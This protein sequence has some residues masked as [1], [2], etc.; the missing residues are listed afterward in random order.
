[1]KISSKI[2][3]FYTTLIQY[4]DIKFHRYPAQQDEDLIESI[5]L[6]FK[7]KPEKI[8]TGNGSDEL[9]YLL[10]TAFL[11]PGDE[12]IHTE[13]GF[14]VFPQAIKIAGGVPIVAPDDNFTV[15]VDAIISKLTPKTKLVFLANPN[16]PTGSMISDQELTRLI[17]SIPKSVLLILDWAYCEYVTSGL[18]DAAKLV[19]SNNNVVMLRTFSKLF[20]IAALR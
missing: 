4:N 3:F 5:A 15:S 9:I 14:L 12:A 19:E 20:G 11:N 7:L 10:C 8:L 6:R 1:M 13:Y 18:S 16:N 17:D 2:P